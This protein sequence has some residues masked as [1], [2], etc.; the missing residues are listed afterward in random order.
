MKKLFIASFI[1]SFVFLIATLPAVKEKQVFAES[2]S[3]TINYVSLGDSIAVGYLLDGHQ[4]A[5][6]CLY[7]ST[8]QTYSQGVFVEDSYAN[9]IKLMLEQKAGTDLVNATTFA[10]V[11]DSNSSRRTNKQLLFRV[12]FLFFYHLPTC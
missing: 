2:T 4:S 3:N 6:E 5:N 8:T 11:G 10:K 7:D 1:I 9:Q 12:A